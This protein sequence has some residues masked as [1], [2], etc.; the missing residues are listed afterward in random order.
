MDI[1]E[2]DPLVFITTCGAQSVS[3]F[4]K[5]IGETLPETRESFDHLCQSWFASASEADISALGVEFQGL[6]QLFASL[7]EI[8]FHRHLLV[9]SA[10]TDAE[11]T[12]WLLAY[13]L[14]KRE[15]MVDLFA[16]E[17]INEGEPLKIEQ[18]WADLAHWCGTD[19]YNLRQNTFHVLFHPADGPREITGLL[20]ALAP[21]YCDTLFFVSQASK[22]ML[23][24]APPAAAI[25][26]RKTLEAHLFAIRRL[27]VGLDIHQEKCEALPENWWI[28][29][30]NNDNE[31]IV[32]LSFVGESHWYLQRDQLYR[33]RLLEPISDL[34]VVTRDFRDGV[35][36][37]SNDR[38]ALLNERLDQL[39]LLLEKEDREAKSVLSMRQNDDLPEPST[40]TAFAWVDGSLWSLLGHYEGERFIL[41]A[42]DKKKG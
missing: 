7:S 41:D 26:E 10:Q 24:Y 33:A 34:I 22:K 32:R 2:D 36:D 21:F 16:I 13:W 20:H 3:R 6:S 4:Q 31:A 19:L 39:S 27:A 11:K 23:H 28:H 15:G 8:A 14:K 40:H 9:F 17:G 1:D 5:M 29:A 12:A 25:K 18:S 42:L 38:Y 30:K 37:L 35:V